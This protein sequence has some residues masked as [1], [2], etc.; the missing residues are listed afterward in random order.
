MI[1]T[2][3][4]YGLNP[5]IELKDV[6]VEE[7]WHNG[8]EKKFGIV[9]FYRWSEGAREGHSYSSIVRDIYKYLKEFH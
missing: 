9:V 1:Y 4:Y 3:K 6:R 8:G 2:A 5:L 7:G